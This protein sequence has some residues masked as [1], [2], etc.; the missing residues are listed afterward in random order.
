MQKQPSPPP[1]L[2]QSA[3]DFYV[4]RWMQLNGLVISHSEGALTYLVTV[5]GG[6]LAALLAFVASAQQVRQAPGALWGLLLFT[7]GL[8]LAGFARAH[9]LEAMKALL[10]GW[11]ADF[12]SYRAGQI[13]WDELIIRDKNRHRQWERLG[14]LL[15]WGSFGCFLAGLVV[16][17]FLLFN[18]PR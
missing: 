6:A 8:V 1:Q 13:A 11:S 9:T 12:E 3:F 14:P 5:N 16:A 4:Q 2:P 17:S 7:T 18:L 10:R 15:G